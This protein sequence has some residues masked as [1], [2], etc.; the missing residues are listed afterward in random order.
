[1]I[2]NVI[3]FWTGTHLDLNTFAYGNTTL[4]RDV[5]E[6]SIWS[7]SFFYKSATAELFERVDSNYKDQPA[8]YEGG[9]TYLFS[10]KNHVLH[11]LSHNQCLQEVPQGVWRQGPLKN[12]WQ[13]CKCS[14]ERNSTHMSLIQWS[15]YFTLCDSDWCVHRSDEW[16]SAWPCSSCLVTQ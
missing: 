4:I 13:E 5:V 2:T 6:I 9:A 8:H 14:R 7:Q 1:M 3:H 12:S 10:I 11:V 16:D 15:G